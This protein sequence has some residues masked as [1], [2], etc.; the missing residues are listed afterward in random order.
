MS[1]GIQYCFEDDDIKKV[2]GK[3]EEEQIRRM[4]VLNK[5]KRLTGIISLGDIATKAKN[6]ELFKY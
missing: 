3:M 4:V 2:I 1:K 6:K 5:D